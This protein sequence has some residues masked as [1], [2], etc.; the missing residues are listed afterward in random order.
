MPAGPSLAIANHALVF[1][2]ERPLVSDVDDVPAADVVRDQWSF[3]RQSELAS[4]PWT[5][6][7]VRDELAA[8]VDPP[9]FGWSTAFPLPADFLRLVE[10]PDLGVAWHYQRGREPYSAAAEPA[11]ELEGGAILCNVPGPLRL[12]Y[13]R[14]LEDWALWHPLFARAMAYSLAVIL[15]EAVTQSTAKRQ[16]AEAKRVEVLAIAKRSNAIQR[17][18]RRLSPLSPWLAARGG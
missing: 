12:R 4:H 3:V 17:P 18:P 8:A 6:A 15:A 11:Y 10:L 13:V 9:A 5:F 16:E 1:L 7:T 2:G 14:D